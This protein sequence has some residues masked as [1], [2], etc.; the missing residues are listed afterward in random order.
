MNAYLPIL[1]GL[2]VFSCSSFIPMHACAGQHRWDKT[3]RLTPKRWFQEIAY[4][5]V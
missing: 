4:S 3:D 5:H 2:I 1:L